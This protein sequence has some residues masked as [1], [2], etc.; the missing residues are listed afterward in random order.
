MDVIVIAMFCCQ[1]HQLTEMCWDMCMSDRLKDRVD[2]KAETC[3]TNC[4]ERFVDVS[5][6]IT[7]RFQ[8]MLQRSQ[9]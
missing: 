2:S 6:T 3:L 7:S 8:Q 9:Q 5:L 1:I 4:V